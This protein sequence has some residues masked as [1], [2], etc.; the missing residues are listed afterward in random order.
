MECCKF[1]ERYRQLEESVA[2]FLAELHTLADKF[3]FGKQLMA[4]LHDR[5]VCRIVD[6]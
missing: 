2:T 6:N 5:L 1:Y 3:G 4:A